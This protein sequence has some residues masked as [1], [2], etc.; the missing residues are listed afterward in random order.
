MLGC[1]LLTPY[2]SEMIL[3]FGIMIEQKMSIEEMKR[4]VFP[5]PAVCEIVREA[6]FQIN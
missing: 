4:T 5:H 3:A 1:H 2:A 6:L